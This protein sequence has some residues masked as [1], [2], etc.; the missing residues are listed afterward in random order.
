[1]ARGGGAF[2]GKDLKSRPLGRLSGPLRRQN[3]VAAGI[4]ERREL[5]LSYAIGVA[6]PTSISIDTFG[7]GKLADS[8]IVELYAKHFELK[9]RG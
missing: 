8:R 3:L 6:E 9:P 2:S 7:T 1:M 5:Q 4:A